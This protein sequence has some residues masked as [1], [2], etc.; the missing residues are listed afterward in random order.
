[1]IHPYSHYPARAA[2]RW[3]DRIALI[4]GDRRRT[5]AELNRNADTIALWL[6]QLGMQPG[7]RVA[8]I[9]QN[10]IEYVESVIGIARAGGA[11]VPMLGALTESEH[12][13]M[14]ED[15]DARF[16]IA[17]TPESAQRVLASISGNIRVL[18]FQDAEGIT[19]ISSLPSSTEGGPPQADLPPSSIAHILYSSGTTGRPKGITH[20][21]A[22]VSAAMNFWAH[23][24]ALQPEDNLLGQLALSHFGG[25]AMDSCWIAGGTLVILPEA[26]PVSIL[27]TIEK[28]RISMMLAVPTLLR[29]LLDHPK[30]EQVDLSSLRAVVYAASPAAPS[31]VRRAQQKL[32]S[33]LYTGFGQTEAYGL[34]TLMLPAEHDKALAG[35]E[36]RLT[37]VGRECTQAQ[38]RIRNDEGVDVETG[39]VGEIWICAPWTTP[40]FWQRPELDEAR[41][42]GGW[43]RTGDLGRV[44]EDGYFYL[45]DRKEDMII[46]GGFNVYPAEVENA[47]M[48]HKA[49]AECGVYSVPDKKWG[50]AINASVVLR[51]GHQVTD[52]ELLAFAKTLLARFK[53]PKAIHI[54]DELPKTAVG[55]ILRRILREPYWKDQNTGIHGAE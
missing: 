9:Q 35:K 32:G 12:T 25:R 51:S 28:Q 20:S 2:R 1:M 55:K 14:L 15:A 6:M 30:A 19:N 21:Y 46:T 37:S 26:D 39:E 23:T 41:L 42:V 47:L 7:E 11:L 4:D 48:E 13:F 52:D 5:Y 3:S 24:F 29:I 54:V 34:N 33:V 50:E 8:L 27:D 16:V 10:C 18:S 31:L 38:V 17:M 36:E 49:I 44:D 45:A 22:S 40:G 53:V 43:L